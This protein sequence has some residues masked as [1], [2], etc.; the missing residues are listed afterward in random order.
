MRN[1]VIVYRAI[2]VKIVFDFIVTRRECD[3]FEI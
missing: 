1:R 2:H 3:L